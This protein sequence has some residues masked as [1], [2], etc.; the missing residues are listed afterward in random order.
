MDRFSNMSCE[1]IAIVYRQE[2]YNTDPGV[3]ENES[4]S[5]WYTEW[6][7]V[8]SPEQAKYTA[9]LTLF[10]K[11]N[12]RSKTNMSLFRLCGGRCVCRPT[13]AARHCSGATW[14]KTMPR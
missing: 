12:Q 10:Y 8:E 13:P 3:P 1:T 5:V 11:D 14:L 9:Q 6:L 7:M 4:D 2:D